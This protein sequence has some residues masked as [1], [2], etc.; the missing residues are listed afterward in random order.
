[1]NEEAGFDST[2]GIAEVVGFAALLVAAVAAVVAL[3]QLR[4][5]RRVN[6]ARFLFDILKWYLDDNE[7]RTMFYALDYHQWHFR[8]SDFVLSEEE[9]SIDKLLFVFEIVEHF[10]EIGVLKADEVPILRFEASRVLHNKEMVKYLDW[11]DLEYRKS[12]VRTPAYQKARAFG[13]RVS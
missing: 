6:R 4:T 3:W 11:L 12:G 5:M 8:P 2:F 9:P 1:M 7:L 13:E 10:I